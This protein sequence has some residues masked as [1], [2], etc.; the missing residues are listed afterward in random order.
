MQ[1]LTDLAPGVFVANSEWYPTTSTVVAGPD[2]GCLLIDPGVTVPELR[3]LAADL[4]SAGLRLAAGFA[5]HPHWDHLLWCREL[6]DAPRWAA[7]QA[8]STAERHRERLISD[9]QREV[10]GHDLEVFARLCPLQPGQPAIPWPGPEALVLTH[11]GHASGHSAVFLP[12]TGTLVAGDML[13]DI[14]IPLLDLDHPDPFGSYRAGL[15]LLAAQPVR[16]LVPGHG[17]TGDA[18]EFRRRV[19]ADTAYLDS[20]ARG[21]DPADP[22]LTQDWLRRVHADQLDHVRQHRP[23]IAFHDPVNEWS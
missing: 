18:A 10:P 8:V 2:G 15:A 12:G 5:T 9:V 3:L 17:S 19:A 23:G 16:R 7:P 4:A 1:R 14:E 21:E 6:G 13:S 22:R 11:D 20:L